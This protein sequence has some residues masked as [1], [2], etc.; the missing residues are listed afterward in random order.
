MTKN[1][2][3][4]PPLLRD[5][6]LELNIKTGDYLLIYIVNAGYGEEIESFHRKNPI[7]PL[8]VFGIMIKNQVN[9]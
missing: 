9:M 6:V 3:V 4:T 7:Y 5:E 8:F 1:I 2:I